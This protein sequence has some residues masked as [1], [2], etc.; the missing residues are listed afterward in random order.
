MPFPARCS[1]ELL[2]GQ[3]MQAVPGAAGLCGPEPGP[4]PL[5]AQDTGEDHKV[6]RNS[7]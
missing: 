3:T 4:L 2:W 5:V 6:G 1:A 7:G